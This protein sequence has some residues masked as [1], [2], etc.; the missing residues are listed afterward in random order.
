MPGFN[1]RGPNG[2]GPGIGWGRGPCGLGMRRGASGR[3]AWGQQTM[4]NFGGRPGRGYGGA[5]GTAGPGQAGYA[6]L[7]DEAEAL[8]NE[9]A[10][11]RSE[12]E[13]VQRRLAALESQG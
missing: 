10:S 12:L 9:A 2:Q 3:R 11:L 6:P 1:G 13:A 4:G 7:Q 5:F 8:R